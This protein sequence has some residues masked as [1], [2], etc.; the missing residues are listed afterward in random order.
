MDMQ[1]SLIDRVYDILRRAD[2]TTT[3]QAFSREYVGKNPNWS[4]YQAHMKRDFSITGAIN[5]LRS[6]RLQKEREAALGIVQLCALREAE[7]LLL[8][9][10][11][12]RYC[13]ADI[14]A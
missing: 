13:V 14:C 6:I 12:E 4:A 11:N 7:G 3:R 8:E 10:L 5:C 2:L 1:T 9:H